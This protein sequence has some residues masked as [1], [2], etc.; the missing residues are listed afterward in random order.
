MARSVGFQTCCI[1][2]FQAGRR[3]QA[4]GRQE[5][6]PIAGLRYPIEFP[7]EYLAAGDSF[8]DRLIDIYLVTNKMRFALMGYEIH[9]VSIID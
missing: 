9:G 3:A 1:A 4:D 5:G 8:E 7:L 6:A 2:D